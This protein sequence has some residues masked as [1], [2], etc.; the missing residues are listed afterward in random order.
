MKKKKKTAGQEPSDEIIPLDETRLTSEGKTEP[1][2][3]ESL[4][5]I[6]SLEEDILTSLT[7][8]S[9]Y[10]LEICRAIEASSH[11]RQLLKIGSLY[12]S[13]HRL[14]KKGLVT[15]WMS[16]SGSEKRRGNRR[17]YYKMTDQGRVTLERKQEMR[18]QLATWS[19]RLVP[20]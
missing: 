14:E 5:Q 6:T 8:N 4:P 1:V 17:K 11:G 10:G 3:T 18:E 20:G 16:K 19:E 13:L 12:P 15:S 2:V 9:L 7:H